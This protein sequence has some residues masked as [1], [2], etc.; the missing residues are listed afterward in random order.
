MKK[1]MILVCVA[2]L[3]TAPALADK[4]VKPTKQG[5]DRKAIAAVV[6][7]CVAAFN[8]GDAE[9]LAAHWSPTGQYIS[10][11]TGEKISGR[12]ALEKDFAALFADDESAQL[13]AS[14]ISLRFLTSDVAVEEGSATVT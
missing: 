1:I 4:A 11:N 7:S 14:L 2:V 5:A 12:E 6:D 13:D 9:A 3:G 10:R 8:R